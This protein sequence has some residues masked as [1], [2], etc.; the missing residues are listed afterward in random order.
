MYGDF[1]FHKI[2]IELRFIYAYR[3]YACIQFNY[4]NR[5]IYFLEFIRTSNIYIEDFVIIH[6]AARVTC[7][8]S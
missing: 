3:G 7:I 5:F 8:I 4:S 2:L 1:F 6:N